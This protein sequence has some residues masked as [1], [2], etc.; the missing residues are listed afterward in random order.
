MIIEGTGESHNYCGNDWRV[1]GLADR[2]YKR[3]VEFNCMIP[4]KIPLLRATKDREKT[5]R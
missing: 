3:N 1:G 4:L 2:G 5:F